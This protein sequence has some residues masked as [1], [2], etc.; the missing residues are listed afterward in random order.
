M[1]SKKPTNGMGRWI[2][3]ERAGGRTDAQTDERTNEHT[4]GRTSKGEKVSER[5]QKR[6]VDMPTVDSIA[7]ERKPKNTNGEDG[8]YNENAM[9]ERD[10]NTDKVVTPRTSRDYSQMSFFINRATCL[11]RQSPS[12]CGPHCVSL[13]GSV[14]MCE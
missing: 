4:D 7:K 2:A 1:Q 11:G 13:G 6:R 3:A 14:E 8:E 5:L 10:I 9:N 12:H